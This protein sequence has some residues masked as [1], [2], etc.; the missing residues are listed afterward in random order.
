MVSFHLVDLIG[1]SAA[2]F[3]I[4]AA[5]S[6][7]MIRLR[8]A[9]IVGNALALTFALYNGAL[10]TILVNAVVLPL[11][12]LRLLDMVKQVRAVKASAEGDFNIDWLRPF[13][14][15]RRLEANETLFSRGDVAERAYFIRS[16][17]VLLPEIGVRLGPGKL[18]GEMGLISHGN[19]RSQSAVAEGP[20]DLLCISYSDFKELALQNP[21]FGFYLMRLIVQRL[22]ANQVVKAALPA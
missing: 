18:F 4:Y 21:E 2:A 12:T 19:A 1:Y 8:A 3:N 17:T 5:V 14:E 10:P 9:A 15:K 20:V 7:T 22:E 16:G 13:M 6:K 11:N